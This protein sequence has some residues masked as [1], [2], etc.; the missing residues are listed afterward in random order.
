MSVSLLSIVRVYILDKY[1]K[2]SCNIQINTFFAG[3]PNS[4]K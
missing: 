1:K 3:S 2:C 4:L